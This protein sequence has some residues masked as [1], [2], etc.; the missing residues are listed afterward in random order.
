[1]GLNVLL[2]VLGTLEGL[3]AEVALVRLERNVYANVRSDVVALH[4]RGPARV[5]LASQVEVVGALPANMALTDVVLIIGVRQQVL[6]GSGRHY[7]SRDESTYIERLGSVEALVAL[8]PP[9]SEILILGDSVR[10]A[11]G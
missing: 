5:P 1:M 10:R 8:I 4:C 3:S 6:K 2:Q 9:A 11:G 7:T